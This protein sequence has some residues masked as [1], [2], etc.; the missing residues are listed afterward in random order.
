M[1]LLMMPALAWPGE[2]VQLPA[3]KLIL[4]KLFTPIVMLPHRGHKL[5]RPQPGISTTVTR[6]RYCCLN[7]RCTHAF[8]LTVSSM[9]EAAS[10][11]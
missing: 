3:V 11:A 4:P 6:K 9:M 10:A 1:P 5:S 7:S 8:M 2:V